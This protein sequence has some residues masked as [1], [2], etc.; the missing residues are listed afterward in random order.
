[1]GTPP[2][3]AAALA[4]LGSSTTYESVLYDDLNNGAQKPVQLRFYGSDSRKLQ[5][6]TTDFMAKMR[7]IK[8]AVDVGYSE[9][10]AQNELQIELDRGLANQMGISVN[11]AARSSRRARR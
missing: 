1:M 10:D 11:D 8:G 3:G 6:I 7:T 5:E 9:L 4:S 2:W